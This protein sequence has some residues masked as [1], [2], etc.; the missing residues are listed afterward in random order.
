MYAVHC[1]SVKDHSACDMSIVNLGL[2]T[3][4][5]YV[6]NNALLFSDNSQVHSDVAIIKK[7]RVILLL[8][9]M[10]TIGL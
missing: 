7:D 1:D 4:V 3:D 6:I 8:F 5:V 2:A 9:Q 10:V